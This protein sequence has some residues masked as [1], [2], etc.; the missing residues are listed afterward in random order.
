MT[1]NLY[2]KKKKP[3][4]DREEDLKSLEEEYH[5]IREDWRIMGKTGRGVLCCHPVTQNTCCNFYHIR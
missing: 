3:L 5:H 1:D 2:T 4:N